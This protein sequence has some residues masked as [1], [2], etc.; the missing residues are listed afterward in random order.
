[1]SKLGYQLQIKRYQRELGLDDRT[2]NALDVKYNDIN[3]LK[4]LQIL[5]PIASAPPA[6]PAKTGFWG[7]F[8]VENQTDGNPR[9]VDAYLAYNDVPVTTTQR[10][11]GNSSYAFFISDTDRL[12]L[13]D[14]TLQL[15]TIFQSGTQSVV[16]DSYTGFGI[17]GNT[18]NPLDQ[19]NTLSMLVNLDSYNDENSG[20]CAVTY[21]VTYVP[22]PPPPNTGW[23]GKLYIVNTI[24]SKGGQGFTFSASTANGTINVT[25]QYVVAGT[26]YE[27]EVLIGNRLPTNATISFMIDYFDNDASGYE[28]AYINGTTYSGTLY[29]SATLDTPAPSNNITITIPVDNDS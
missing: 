26:T 27:I 13:P 1:M 5:N 9:Y 24:I 21:I 12:P 19:E 10:I 17:T 28:A 7:T 25:Q 20:Y 11:N 4:Q 15:K 8:L 6:P 23:Y 29:S 22:P 16:L 2:F 3:L 14:S 18:Q